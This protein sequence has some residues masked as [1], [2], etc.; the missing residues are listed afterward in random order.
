MNSLSQIENTYN[1]KIIITSDNIH[2][3][4]SN[5]IKTKKLKKKILQEIFQTKEYEIFIGSH[6][7]SL[8]SYVAEWQAHNILYNY[9]LFATRTADVD[10]DNNE[11]LI[12][13]IFYRM[14][15]VLND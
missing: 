11:S 10:L 14:L 8:G 4:N 15:S 12:R 5:I 6:I 7:R 1:I 9:G 2:I 13:R 3:E